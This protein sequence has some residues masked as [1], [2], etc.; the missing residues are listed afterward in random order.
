MLKGPKVDVKVVIVCLAVVR[1]G[2]MIAE[3][4]VLRVL[5]HRA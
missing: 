4:V 1:V 2:F 3:R 5:M